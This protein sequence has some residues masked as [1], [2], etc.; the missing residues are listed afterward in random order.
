VKLRF[1]DLV[2]APYLLNFLF[3]ALLAKYSGRS[4]CCVTVWFE[5]EG[6]VIVTSAK[7]ESESLDVTTKSILPF[8]FVSKEIKGPIF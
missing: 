7:N 8:P 2:A 3:S 4:I 1:I 6:W 5:G